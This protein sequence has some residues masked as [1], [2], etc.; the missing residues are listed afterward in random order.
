[1]YFGARAALFS[2]LLFCLFFLK[3]VKLRAS[4]LVKINCLLFSFLSSILLFWF[5]LFFCLVQFIMW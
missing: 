4:Y 1:M 2:S 5:E 3:D